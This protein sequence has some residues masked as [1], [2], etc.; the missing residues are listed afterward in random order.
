MSRVEAHR[1]AMD[2]LSERIVVALRDLLENKHLYQS[3]TVT[4]KGLM[5]PI[6]SQ[7]SDPASI[8]AELEQIIDSEWIPSD[9]T[10]ILEKV[11]TGVISA[12]RVPDP[13]IVIRA[14]D[15]RLFCGTCERQEP[16]NL[17]SS[18]DILPRNRGVGYHSKAGRVQV[19]QFSYLCQSC[20]GVPEVFLVRRNGSRLT[21]CGRAPM[22]YAGAPVDVPRKVRSFYSDAL[23]AYQ[24]GQVLAANFLLRT[25]IEQ[26]AR[27]A[28][29][30]TLAKDA[31]EILTSYMDTLP[32][33]FKAQFP[34][35][36]SLYGELSH[37]IHG[38]VGSAELF[39]RV[40]SE[41]VEHFEARRLFKIETPL[42][43]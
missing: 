10:A 29:V 34:S 9:M 40:R 39:E 19:L 12:N 35:L 14:P 42:G 21:L 33:S 4:F 16:F 24:S 3:V 18:A 11:S 26:W 25:L 15:I 6:A 30:K 8:Q 32:A 37:D 31:D 22:E 38:A 20:K 36:R 2:V 7:T 13:V 28:S 23:I 27:I 1:Q 43:T 5:E 41:V 17:V